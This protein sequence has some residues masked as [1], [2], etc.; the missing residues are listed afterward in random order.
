MHFNPKASMQYQ[1]SLIEQH[2][3]PTIM[4]Q[5]NHS[6]IHVTA[7]YVSHVFLISFNM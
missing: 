3:H 4:L 5:A 6:L 2:V 1:R 7:V